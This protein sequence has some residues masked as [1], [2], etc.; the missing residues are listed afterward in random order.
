[1]TKKVNVYTEQK[2]TQHSLNLGFPGPIILQWAQL[3]KTP[4]KICQSW[5]Q[6]W[7]R[8]MVLLFYTQI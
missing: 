2:Y 3:L 7:I 5:E 4:Y 1:M 8:G 6:S